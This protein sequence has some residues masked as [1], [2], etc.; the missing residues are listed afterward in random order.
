MAVNTV[1]FVAHRTRIRFLFEMKKHRTIVAGLHGDGAGAIYDMRNHIKWRKQN[2][3]EIYRSKSVP[4]KK[5]SRMIY[6]L[7]GTLCEKPRERR[8]EVE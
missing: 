7:A 3:K 6:L 1:T 2:L 4:P 5:H 8:I